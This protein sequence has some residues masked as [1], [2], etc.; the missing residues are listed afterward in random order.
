MSY[1]YFQF[2]Q[3]SET[4]DR[5]SRR[6]ENIRSGNTSTESLSV[7]ESATQGPFLHPTHTQIQTDHRPNSNTSPRLVESQNENEDEVTHNHEGNS[8]Q[9]S[10]LEMTLGNRLEMV[11]SHSDIKEALNALISWTDL[12]LQ[13]TD[14]QGDTQFQYSSLFRRSFSFICSFL[15]RATFL[16]SYLPFIFLLTHFCTIPL[17][18]SFTL[19]SLPCFLPYQ[20]FYFHTYFFTFIGVL[21][22]YF[23]L[24]RCISL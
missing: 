21:S 14:S 7:M 13:N 22:S 15:H 2:F 19:F 8:S 23:F 24:S 3:E 20:C 11:A 10:S 5:S 16:I 12:K 6:K 1:F 4:S 18:H 17:S 9:L